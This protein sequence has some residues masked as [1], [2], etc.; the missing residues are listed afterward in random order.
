MHISLHPL[1]TSRYHFFS[2]R[3]LVES[4]FGMTY[5]Y[6]GVVGTFVTIIVAVIVSYITA[7]DDDTYDEKLLHPM[8]ITI[9]QWWR[10][11]TA[12]A[13]CDR[14][15]N[16]NQAFEF[17]EARTDGTTTSDGRDWNEFYAPTEGAEENRKTSDLRPK[18]TDS[19]LVDKLSSINVS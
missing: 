13:N 11:D 19:I 18:T 1:T 8:V 15:A 3:T 10:G 5:M 12:P 6:Y 16:I 17:T 9:R 4:L 7:S 14:S 2:C